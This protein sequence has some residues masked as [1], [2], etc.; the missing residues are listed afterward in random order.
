M[1]ISE[2]SIC[3]RA[4]Y[5]VGGER[6]NSF[7][8]NSKEAQI[9]KDLY[10]TTRDSVLQSHPWNFATKRK[11]FAQTTATP[12]FEFSYSYKVPTDCL[13]VLDLWPFD[14][15]IR[16]KV[17][18][19]FV[20]TDS[21]SCKAKYIWKVTNTSLFSPSF[22]RAL[23]Y[24]MAVE[25]AYALTNSSTIQQTA[26]TRAARYWSFVRSQDAQEGTPDSLDADEWLD[27]RY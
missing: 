12:E 22:A 8:D 15:D 16:F 18:S 3:N 21:N 20:L 4:L 10:A 11:I 7:N 13:R 27:S 1:A 9:C 6:I 14:E 25:L 19:G 23:S 5:L 24:E 26:E 17:E 2:S